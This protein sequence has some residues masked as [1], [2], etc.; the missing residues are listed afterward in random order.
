MVIETRNS[1]PMKNEGILFEISKALLISLY[2][3]R[4]S[5]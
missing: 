4:K 1:K 2:V 5:E 3:F